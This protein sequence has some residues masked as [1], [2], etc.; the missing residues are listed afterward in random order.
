MAAIGIRHRSC[1]TIIAACRHA[2]QM[3]CRYCSSTA[4]IPLLNATCFAFW[5]ADL[6]RSLAA[7]ALS[8]LP[9]IGRLFA[10]GSGQAPAAALPDVVAADA[11]AP[12]AAQT[13]GA[14]AASPSGAPLAASA[15]LAADAGSRL[16]RVLVL[17]DLHVD[18]AGGANQ[19][20]LESISATAFSRDV[21]VVAGARLCACVRCSLSVQSPKGRRPENSLT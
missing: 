3:L 10:P 18:R 15:A 21:L 9:A 17:S 14:A 16:A 12:A 19:R 11:S 6:Q 13:D 8:V 5:P 20:A 4:G 1:P 7:Q 2:C